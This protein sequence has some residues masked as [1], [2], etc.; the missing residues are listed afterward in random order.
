MEE[1]TAMNGTHE[2]DELTLLREWGR[3]LVD[4]DARPDPARRTEVLARAV[5]PAGQARPPVPQPRRRG[6]RSVLAR[7]GLLVGAAAAAAIAVLV[8]PTLTTNGAGP[9]ADSAAAAVLHQAAQAAVA[10]AAS[11]VPEGSFVYTESADRYSETTVTGD[12][13]SSSRLGPATDRRIWLPA[14]GQAPGLLQTRPHDGSGPWDDTTLG[15]CAS[16]K[17]GADTPSVSADCEQNPQPAYLRDLPQTADAMFTYLYTHSHGDNPPDVQAF[18]TVGDLLREN[19]LPPAAE[20]ALFQAAARIPGTVVVRDEHDAL[21]RPATAVAMNSG[22]ARDELLFDPGSGA[23]LGEKSVLLQAGTLG[24]AGTVVG[25]S[26]V[27][28]TAIVARAGQLP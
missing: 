15:G 20:A 27:L 1:W 7:R 26:A 24:P 12:G 11:P 21:G 13:D 16:P 23:F 2:N 28:R 25:S 17:P 6:R 4:D 9:P 5:R 22:T 10:R 8:M 18:I 19:Y 14:Y 3:V